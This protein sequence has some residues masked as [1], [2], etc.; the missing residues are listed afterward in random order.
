MA[1][2]NGWYFQADMDVHRPVFQIVSK[3]FWD[4]N[5]C[6]NDSHI[7]EDLGDLLPVGFFEMCESMFEIDGIDAASAK[8]KLLKAG[9]EEKVLFED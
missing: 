4:A 9:F 8:N 1:K 3:E 2:F 5:D 6:L 7:T